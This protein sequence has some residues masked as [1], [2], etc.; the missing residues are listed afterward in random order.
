M[1]EKGGEGMGNELTMASSYYQDE[2]IQESIKTIEFIL[3]HNRNQRRLP[4]ELAVI[5]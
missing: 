4:S 5:D 2:Y 1:R 3:C